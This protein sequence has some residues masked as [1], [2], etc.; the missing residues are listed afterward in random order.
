MENLSVD[1]THIE[2]L[3]EGQDLCAG[4]MAEGIADLDGMTH[5]VK[6]A[7]GISGIWW[8]HGVVCQAGITA[9]RGA[10]EA[11]QSAAGNM[12]TVSTELAEKLRAAAAAY[13]WTDEQTGDYVAS[14]M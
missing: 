11:R 8:D 6:T 14:H 4:E 2:Q 1:P 12:E 5:H 7:Q 13:S 3:A 9:L 10:L